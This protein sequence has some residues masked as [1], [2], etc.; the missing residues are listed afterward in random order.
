MSLPS[1]ALI[2]GDPF[3][4][5]QALAERHEAI[6]ATDPKTERHALFGDEVDLSGLATELSSSALFADGR[7]FIVRHA[8]AIKPK[9]FQRLAEAPLSPATYVT[10]VAGEL[11]ASSPLVKAAR[12]SATVIAAPRPAGMRLEKAASELFARASLR[13]PPRTVKAFV[14]RSGGDLLALSGE[15]DKLRAY[16][17]TGEAVPDRVEQLVFSAGETSMYP[18]LDR[19]GE[20]DTRA[21][22]SCLAELHDDP[23]RL[24]AASVRHLS[25][26][27]MLRSLLDLKTD[28]A[29]LSSLLG[30]PS[31]LVSRLAG[32]AKRHTTDE[33]KT[34]LERAIDLDT[35]VKRGL[36]RPA[37]ALLL[38]VFA[39]TTGRPAAP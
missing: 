30:A 4:C 21:A 33:L 32:Q 26:L 18:L 25:R 3:R 39:A 23:G 14:E 36:L 7:H 19:I 10:F 20:R 11:K 8:E 27:A 12:E 9:A 24:L 5:D 2:F 38:L 28:K 13:L 16:V 34:S 29:T 22:L 6:L 37:D 31:W 15:A 1:V 17:S 35:G